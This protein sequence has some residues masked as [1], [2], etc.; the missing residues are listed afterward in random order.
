VTGKPE[1]GNGNA[2]M[3]GVSDE[4]FDSPIPCGLEASRQVFEADLFSNNDSLPDESNVHA[5]TN[6]ILYLGHFVGMLH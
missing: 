3:R 2:D 5:A 6:R 1:I 4:A